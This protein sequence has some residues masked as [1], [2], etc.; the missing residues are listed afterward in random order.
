MV[1]PKGSLPLAE[2]ANSAPFPKLPATRVSRKF[3]KLLSTSAHP[4]P[5]GSSAM[6]IPEPMAGQAMVAANAVFARKRRYTAHVFPARNTIRMAYLRHLR[7]AHPAQKAPKAS[8]R[9]EGSGI[10]AASN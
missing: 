9:E 7:K 2:K 3:E 10:V 6:G 4:E 5:T 8:A 1:S